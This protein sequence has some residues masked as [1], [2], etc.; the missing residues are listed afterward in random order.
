MDEK[1]F[2][3]IW[4]DMV[5][6]EYLDGSRCDA[7][8]KDSHEFSLYDS[9]QLKDDSGEPLPIVVEE[10]ISYMSPDCE[11]THPKD[12]LSGVTANEEV[13]QGTLSGQ[14]L[15]E[16]QPPGTLSGQTLN[17]Q[18]PGTL[19][20][21][22]TDDNLRDGNLSIPSRRNDYEI[23]FE[24]NRGGMGTISCGRQA[25][26]KRDI[27]VK[28]IL[29]QNRN[30]AS[31]R[32][33]FISEALVTAYLDHPN[34]VPVYQ[35]SYDEEQNVIL[36]MKLIDGVSWKT[37][38]RE[39][40]TQEERN[41]KLIDN[42]KI[43]INV[44]NA[45]AYAHNKGIIHN[46]LKP[47]NI[48]VG[49]F[50]EVFVMDWG[51]SVDISDEKKEPRTLHKSEVVKPMGTPSY[52]P[53]ELA[54]GRGCDIG[55]W[56]DVYLLGAILYELITGRPPHY[57]ET[58][59]LSL[60]SCREGLLPKFDDDISEELQG[61]CYKALSKNKESRYQSIQEFQ[62][63]IED[64]LKHR[65]SIAIEEKA[66]FVLQKC[67]N[68]V[69][70][71]MKNHVKMQETQRNRLYSE[72]AQAVAFF[73]Q[74][75]MLWRGNY[76]AHRGELQARSLY[77]DFA[78][79]NGDIGLAEAQA[80]LLKVSNHSQASTTLGKVQKAKKNLHKHQKRYSRLRHML[81]GAIVLIIVGLT[82][83]TLSL[84]EEKKRT[85]I[86]TAEAARQREHA[87]YRRNEAINRENEAKR[88][89]EKAEG[90][91]LALE[92]QKKKVV[93][94]A[95]QA[96]E[97]LAQIAL[98]KANEAYEDAQWKNCG[99]YA[100][101]GL[102]LIKDFSENTSA[103]LRRKNRSFI[104]LALQKENLI[105]KTNPGYGNYIH[106][107]LC[108][109]EDDLLITA[110]NDKEIRVWST[111]TGKQSFSLSGHAAAIRN[112]VH[113]KN[114]L[115]SA[116]EDKTIRLWNLQTRKQIQSIYCDT[117]A[118]NCMAY[119]GD[120]LVVGGQGEIII[121]RP[122][123]GIFQIWRR[124]K[125]QANI[126]VKDMKFLS[127]KL[128]LVAY[129]S[130]MYLD[131]STGD[132]VR[133]FTSLREVKLTAVSPKRTV[134]AMANDAHIVLYKNNGTPIQK[135]SISSPIT[136]LVFIPNNILFSSH[137]NGMVNNWDLSKNSREKI[138]HNAAIIG[139]AYH[140]KAQ[141]LFVSTQDR[142]VHV[143]NDG[144][145]KSH[146]PIHTKEITSVAFNF[147][148]DL[149]ASSAK[150]NTIRIWNTSTGKQ[151]REISAHKDTIADVAFHPQKNLLA[152][153]SFD[154]K[155]KLWDLE[156]DS[157]V[158]LYG[159]NDDITQV[160]VH[161]KGAVFASGSKD[162]DICIWQIPSGNQQAVL[163]GHDKA[164]TAL[165]YNND[166]SMLAS[167]GEDNAVCVWQGN[168]LRFVLREHTGKINKLLFHP[169][170]SL[171]ASAADD[172]RVCLWDAKQGKLLA[173]FAAHRAPVIS[174]FFFANKPFLFSGGKDKKIALWNLQS[175][176][177]VKLYR[178][179]R[180]WVTDLKGNFN[181][182]ICVSTSSDY[183][184]IMWN[185]RF[186]EQKRFSHS[187]DI[188]AID[189]HDKRTMFATSAGSNV[190]IWDFNGTRIF[191]FQGHRSWVKGVAFRP[192]TEELASCSSD[193][194]ICI[195]N[196][197]SGRKIKQFKQHDSDV[198]G[199]FYTKGGRYLISFSKSDLIIW[200]AQQKRLLT[201]IIS[202]HTDKINDICFSPDGK[203]LAS[204]SDDGLV[205]IWN[206]N[207]KKVTAEFEGHN[208]GI[209]SVHYSPKGKYLA[210]ASSD[211]TIRIWDVEK[212][213][214]TWMLFGNDGHK[215]VVHKVCYNG[216]GNAV[217]TAS[218]DGVIK[219]W[220]I[221]TGKAYI[222]I[223]DMKNVQ[224]LQYTKDDQMLIIALENNIQLWDIATGAPVEILTGHTDFV[225]DIAYS[226]D[227]KKLLSGSKDKTLRLWTIPAQP[228][229]TLRRGYKNQKIH[230]IAY[231]PQGKLFTTLS[232]D[233]IHIWNHKDSRPIRVK[234]RRNAKMSKVVFS[235]NGEEI[236]S[237]SEDGKIILWDSGSLDPLY[238]FATQSKHI[239]QIQYN[240]DASIL[241][242][243]SVDTS[244]NLW[245]IERATS[246]I[247]HKKIMQFDA[248]LA[249]VNSITFH[250]NDQILAS[251]SEDNTI[252]LWDT[253]NNEQ[254]KVISRH[255]A[256]VNFVVFSASGEFLASASDDRT[257]R[258]WDTSDWKQLYVLREHSQPIV[259]LMFRGNSL[260]STAADNTILLWDVITGKLVSRF[261]HSSSE[262]TG[263]A[264]RPDGK[265][266]ISTSADA[267]IRIWELEQAVKRSTSL[268]SMPTW[269]RN[270]IDGHSEEVK[271]RKSSFD[272][273]S[274]IPGY[275]LEVAISTDPRI[276]TENL[277]DTKTTSTFAVKNL[278]PIT[279]FEMK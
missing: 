152:S 66:R 241:A 41:D 108:I 79:L 92:K 24:I 137:K 240:S 18:Q 55:P 249:K 110:A 85:E 247:R 129:K 235:Y 12:T 27:A 257:I 140:Q 165:A 276:V 7:T 163:S 156:N 94:E 126:T 3:K 8:F 62:R 21:Q 190:Y 232:H 48:M 80:E 91:A 34:I 96:K 173:V 172:N 70:H 201:K 170:K 39:N 102:D 61:I 49:K 222:T 30:I 141:T 17:E 124:V 119:D 181:K 255:K 60:I 175:K 127:S 53:I 138:T 215:D 196:C 154:R 121:F 256:A 144:K 202:G 147:R 23:F 223:D 169:Q 93:E 199:V 219:I 216:I 237:A 117:F 213:K 258:I 68:N 166:G 37:L 123:N 58:V 274:D 107:M 54:E 6:E 203:E 171:L 15:N 194:S 187:S 217:A 73:E 238:S 88:A 99:V 59:W 264:F 72:F 204:V 205:K 135:I 13:V 46:D 84:Q 76:P 22:T 273:R 228:Q 118:V 211:K 200:D 246:K 16:Q 113:D 182:R 9:L 178:K 179:H 44:C 71:L 100:G 33:K 184:A 109:D 218:R 74:A 10:D 104:R 236:A 114:I 32:Q 164:I 157:S 271:P 174:L 20:G 64:Y 162:S 221:A 269:F 197:N 275:L 28:Q 210:T 212:G 106:K 270:I 234:K 198:N 52:I 167:G 42:I 155:V 86:Q 2:R 279:L 90:Y 265:G 149:A 220:N 254:L 98:Q 209:E 67:Q 14:T 120:T 103:N 47:D 248:H 95:Q 69:E 242:S 97:T 159:H 101:I 142:Y 128:L 176:K 183:N 226:P 168:K 148:G 250:P 125:L 233:H 83:F 75:Q 51:I 261:Q 277:F 186:Q 227:G 151:V 31:H 161:P 35:L 4:E 133:K 40:S 1:S 180:A 266:F 263:M 134:L 57:Q 253:K 132:I 65:E 191:K 145:R 116:S 245:S 267:T 111:V 82:L 131:I 259:S 195:W 146:L 29:P 230:D 45:V 214:A 208:S 260:I 251:A 56:T 26:L 136:D 130:G 122:K 252:R 177:L 189:F 244:I 77:A 25:S 143:W 87:Y 185:D 193:K 272:L 139:M 192:Q 63:A 112:I 150:D 206:I 158:A 5:S 36:S 105:W 160:A 225:T 239:T 11:S 224:S 188:S 207:T 19:S 229:I 115:V 81:L 78:L 38:L 50:G 231:H 89:K 243:S 43:L 153:A 262:I 278:A 268:D